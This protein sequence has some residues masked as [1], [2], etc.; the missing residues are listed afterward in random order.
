MP[1]CLH[2]DGFLLL[3][4]VE[5]RANARLQLD[6]PAHVDILCVLVLINVLIACNDERKGFLAVGN[7]VGLGHILTFAAVSTLRRTGWG[8]QQAPIV[9]SS[10]SNQPLAAIV[11]FTTFSIVGANSHSASRYRLRDAHTTKRPAPSLL[12]RRVRADQRQQGVPRH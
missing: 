7:G 3:G 9:L 8:D 11:L 5:I 4:L 12:A 10:L 1:P 2:H 6:V